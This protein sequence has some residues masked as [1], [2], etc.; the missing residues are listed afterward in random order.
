MQVPETGKK[1]TK[2]RTFN[3]YAFVVTVFLMLS[4]VGATVYVLI[5]S[6]L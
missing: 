5:S 6:L 1:N 4:F 3:I 2:E